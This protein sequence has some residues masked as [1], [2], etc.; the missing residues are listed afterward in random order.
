M[1]LTDDD[2]QMAVRDFF[3]PALLLEFIDLPDPVS[4]IRWGERQF[5]ERELRRGV[6]RLD[7][8]PDAGSL[9][10]WSAAPG[11]FRY[12]VDAPGGIRSGCVCWHDVHQVVNSRLNPVRYG[13]LR[14]AVEAVAA[15]DAAYLPGPAPFHTPEVWESTFYRPWARRA[16]E[17]ALKAA[18]AL[19]AICPAVRA[20]PFLF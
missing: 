4:R 12:E 9:T 2:L 5:G 1:N 18:A 10:H 20:Q 6:R 14:A 8:E 17:L 7:G 3:T 16:S 13:A 11:G 15:H 19:D